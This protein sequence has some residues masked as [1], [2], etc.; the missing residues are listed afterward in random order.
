M[1]R[2]EVSYDVDYID[3]VNDEV[4]VVWALYENFI[5]SEERARMTALGISRTH[6]FANARVYR[7]TRE[8]VAAYRNGEE[9]P[10][11]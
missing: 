4:L 10:K 7:V 8:L 5:G 3:Q 1:D 11:P 2:P 6:E 9:L